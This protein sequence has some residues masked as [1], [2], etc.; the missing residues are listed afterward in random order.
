MSSDHVRAYNI[1]AKQPDCAAHFVAQR[2]F[3]QVAAELLGVCRVRLYFDSLII[4]PRR[5]GCRHVSLV[6]CP[7]LLS[8]LLSGEPDIS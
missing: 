1:W 3:G 4:K 5:Y 6:S 8:R 7:P 2:R